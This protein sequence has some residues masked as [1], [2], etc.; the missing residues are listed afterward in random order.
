MFDLEF[1]DKTKC[2][3]KLLKFAKYSFT[4]DK[5]CFSDVD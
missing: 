4:D 2:T 5:R 3:Q 1:L